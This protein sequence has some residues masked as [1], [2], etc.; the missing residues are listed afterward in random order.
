MFALIR[1]LRGYVRIYVTGYSTERFMNLCCVYGI[2]LWDIEDVY[3]DDES[4]KTMNIAI[5]DF[6]RLRTITRKTK[7]KV[8]ILKK[9]GF[10]FFVRR[11]GQHK[12]FVGGLFLCL[13]ALYVLSKFIWTIELDGNGE[14]TEDIF[15]DFLQAQNVAVGMKIEDLD[16]DGFEKAI[17]NE[18]DYITWASA[19][20][21]GTRLVVSV[22][23]NNVEGMK[24]ETSLEAPTD[25]LANQDGTIIAMI[26]R[27]GVPVKK[28]GDTVTK[29]EVLVS[30]QIPILNDDGTTKGWHYC[31]ADADVV[32]E[33]TISFS[34]KMDVSYIKKEPTG[35]VHTRWG[36]KIGTLFF[37][38][39]R[40]GGNTR[41][42]GVQEYTQLQIM[43]DFYLPVFYGKTVYTEYEKKRAN[44]TEGE[45][46]NLLLEKYNTYEQSLMEKGVQIVEKNVKIEQKKKTM[47]LSGTIKVNLPIGVRHP[48]VIEPNQTGSQE[49]TEVE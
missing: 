7:T 47:V 9:T 31:H 48:S 11:M 19:K 44:Y 28:I 30:G 29:G 4:G 37:E 3:R 24:E 35:N 10:P 2:C 20:V 32:I 25:L 23:E 12:M 1:F 5:R 41:W 17:R 40:K 27:E 45:L 39:G 18:Y 6:Y 13:F 33:T 16:I 8:H 26:T 22:K 49:E 36:I 43:K 14:L 42:E 46:K 21:I 34:E 15:R 38:I